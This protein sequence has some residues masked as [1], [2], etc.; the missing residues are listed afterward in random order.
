MGIDIGIVIHREGQARRM[1]VIM[2]NG[3]DIRAS[4]PHRE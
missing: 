2:V 1:F 3:A 4:V